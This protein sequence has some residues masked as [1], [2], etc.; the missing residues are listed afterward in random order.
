M[1]YK[2]HIKNILGST[3]ISISKLNMKKELNT[4]LQAKVKLQMLILETKNR[5]KVF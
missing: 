3:E 4:A 1:T 2:S 5:I